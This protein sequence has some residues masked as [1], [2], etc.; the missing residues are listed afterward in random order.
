LLLWKLN[1]LLGNVVLLRQGETKI[2][3]A[4]ITYSHSFVLEHEGHQNSN[5][6]FLLFQ[7][8]SISIILF[9]AL[10][11]LYKNVYFSVYSV[12]FSFVSNSFIRSSIALQSYVVSWPLLHFCSYTK[13]VGFL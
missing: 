4:I 9:V 12:I 7:A 3:S 1:G 13:L 8:T 5:V 10:F 2:L 11:L 6:I